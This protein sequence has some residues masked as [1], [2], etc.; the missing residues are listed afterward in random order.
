MRPQHR[1]VKNILLPDIDWVEIPSG[2]FIYGYGETR[3]S[4]YLS[5]FYISRYPITN[6]QYQAFINDNGYKDNKWWIDLER[7]TLK[8][9]TWI[10]SNRPK[11][12]ISW[13]EAVAFTRWLSNYLG[14]VVSLPQEQEWEKAARGS[15]GLIY[16]WGNEYKY[17][18]ANI[19]DELKENNLN[20]TIAVGMYPHGASPY[21]IMDMSGNVWEWCLNKYHQSNDINPD[22]NGD[23]RVVRGGSWLSDSNFARAHLRHPSLPFGQE[24]AWGFRIVYHSSSVKTL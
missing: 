19:I 23:M 3:T 20:Q 9:S 18:F 5:S 17:G 15:S 24:D 21:G 10:E 2:N 13:Y 12:N 1:Q 11:V 16:P 6:I 8:E 7:I 22:R 14:Y 4:I